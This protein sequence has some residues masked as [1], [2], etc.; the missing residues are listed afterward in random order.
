MSD[1]RIKLTYD[2]RCALVELSGAIVLPT[3]V[4][5]DPKAR[6]ALEEAFDELKIQVYRDELDEDAYDAVLGW[7][8]MRP[9]ADG[10]MELSEEDIEGLEDEE[11]DSDLFE[12]RRAPEAELAN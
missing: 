1:E 3:A 5:S 2:E 8:E 7:L 9:E 10:L 4:H 12:T 6:Q 11:D